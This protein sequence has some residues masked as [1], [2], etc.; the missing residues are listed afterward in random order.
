MMGLYP[1]VLMCQHGLEFLYPIYTTCINHTST[2]AKSLPREFLNHTSTP[3]QGSTIMI[4]SAHIS[5]SSYTC[6]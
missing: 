6:N 2:V 3:K 4:V 1:V 5:V